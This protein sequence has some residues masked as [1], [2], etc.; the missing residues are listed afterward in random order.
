MLLLGYDQH[1]KYDRLEIIYSAIYTD[2]TTRAINASRIISYSLN[3]SVPACVL[4]Y[5]LHEDATRD[6]EIVKRNDIANA[7]FLPLET[8]KISNS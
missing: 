6:V 1:I 5:D 4:A 3:E 8:L 7:M 2:L